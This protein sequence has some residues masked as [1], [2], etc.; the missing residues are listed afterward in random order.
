MVGEVGVHERPRQPSRRYASWWK[1]LELLLVG[2]V[3]DAHTLQKAWHSTGTAAV[4]MR[5]RMLELLGSR[6]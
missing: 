5:E 6:Q 2:R 4:Q 3:V 1:K